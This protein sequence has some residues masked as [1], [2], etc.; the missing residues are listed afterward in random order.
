MGYDSARSRSG[1]LVRKI[2]NFLSSR[3]ESGTV[4]QNGG[5]A[6]FALLMGGARLGFGVRPDCF[7]VEAADRNRAPWLVDGRAREL[8]RKSPRKPLNRSKWTRKR[9]GLPRS[10][11]GFS[12]RREGRRSALRSSCALRRSSPRVASRPQS[13]PPHARGA[14]RARRFDRREQS[15]RRGRG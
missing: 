4:F 11:G 12:L 14:R 1:T 9:R 6:W 8:T 3:L 7:W 13:R 15:P 10:A 5:Q 2:D